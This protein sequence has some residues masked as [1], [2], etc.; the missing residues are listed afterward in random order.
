ML[1]KLQKCPIVNETWPKHAAA[2]AA[3]VAAAAAAAVVVVAAAA[4][5][6]VAAAGE[7]WVN[8]LVED[9]QVPPVLPAH[10]GVDG[11]LVQLSKTRGH[12]VYVKRQH[13]TASTA[14]DGLDS[15]TRQSPAGQFFWIRNL[16][17]EAALAT[18]LSLSNFLYD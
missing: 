8:F 16:Y 2:A 10:V 14:C 3:V 11:R 18:S 5:A 1:Q 17:F 13:V 4:A 15:L 6:A 9:T 7:L 12:T